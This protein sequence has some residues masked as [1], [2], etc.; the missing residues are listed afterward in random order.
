MNGELRASR[1]LADP[2]ASPDL[3]MDG[4]RLVKMHGVVEPRGRLTVGEMGRGLPFAPRR[5]FVISQVPRT[6]IRGEHAHRRLQQLLVCL[7]GS[8]VAE[9]SDGR[10]WRAVHL[11]CPEVGLYVPPMV[12][13]A[14]HDYS[15][16]AVLLVLASDE[17]D[18]AD[19]IRDIDT[20]R[21]ERS[22]MKP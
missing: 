16:E 9:V 10:R 22:R 7:A 21:A 6:D 15:R 8:V 12:W 3:E 18:A 4:A 19:Y 20:F 14:Q 5:Y 11:D 13:G 17:Y 1:W 2:G